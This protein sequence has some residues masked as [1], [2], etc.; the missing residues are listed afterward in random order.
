M[1]LPLRVPNV[2]AGSLGPLDIRGVQP[3]DFDS[4]LVAHGVQRYKWFRMKFPRVPH[5][6]N[7]LP[8]QA[9]RMQ[10][11]LA[12]QVVAAPLRS[13]ARWIAGLDA[14]FARGGRLCVA[15]V[16]LWDME[17]GKV[18]EQHHAAKPVRFPY[19][20]GLLSFR[21]APALLAALRK[22]SNT[23]DLVMCDGHGLAH[24]RRFGIACHIGLL[25]KLPALGCA[26]SRLIGAHAE[27]GV[28][29]GSQTPLLDGSETIGVVLRTQDRVRPVYVS[30]GYQIDLGTAVALVL[31]C[32][33]K[34]RLPEPTRL[35][36]RYVAQAKH[37][38]EDSGS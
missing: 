14:A 10:R 8:A 30:I 35:A 11:R 32:G 18:Q 36:D 31:A 22:L 15:A 25:C 2:P 27:P 37:F 24:P 16:V 26:K 21:E 34:Y 28:R 5:R 38:Y 13:P 29:R 12:A 17:N 20:P 4:R 33:N 3:I 7:L 23:P 1:N 9:I 19:I 6:W